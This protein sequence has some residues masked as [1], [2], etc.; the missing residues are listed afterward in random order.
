MPWRAALL[1]TLA[2]CGLHFT[3]MAAAG[4]YP[5][6][7][8]AMPGRMI[9]SG[10]LTAAVIAMAAIILS[11]SFAMVVFDRKLI[12]NS[13]DEARRIRAFADAAIEGL[14]V[15]DGERV[16]DANRSFLQLA[17]YDELAAMPATLSALFA[18]FDPLAIPAGSESVASECR[19]IGARTGPS[20]TSRCCCA[21]STGAAPTARCWRCATSAS[22]R[23]RRR[24]SPISPIMTR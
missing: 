23:R 6:P 5:G 7:V 22:A 19:L 13:A 4:I 17:G 20:M 8:D 15:I 10:T 3:A 12:R 24:G 9:G 14:V 16:V 1:F 11:I 21:G 2:I 18:G